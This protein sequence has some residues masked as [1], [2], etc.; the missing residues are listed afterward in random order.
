MNLLRKKNPT[1][2]ERK[3]E[4]NT[5]H[6]FRFNGCNIISKGLFEKNSSRVIIHQKISSQ[7]KLILS[8][9]SKE[10]ITNT[11]RKEVN[12]IRNVWAV[13]RKHDGYS[14][15]FLSIFFIKLELEKSDQR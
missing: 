15:M 6:F 14:K 7:K 4:K 8:F 10:K 11:T 9:S 3:R 12:V 5:H 1:S 2:S 13:R